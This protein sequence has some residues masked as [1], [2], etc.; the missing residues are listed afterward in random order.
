MLLFATLFAAIALFGALIGLREI[1]HPVGAQS[2]ASYGWALCINAGALSA[3][4]LHIRGR[5]AK[6]SQSAQH[7]S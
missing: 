7:R 6:R 1:G 5:R 3:F 4:L 2:I